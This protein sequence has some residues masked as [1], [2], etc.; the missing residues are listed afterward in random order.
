MCGIAGIATNRHDMQPA[1]YEG[2]LTRLRHRGPDDS[3]YLLYSRDA[4]VVSRNGFTPICNPE[5]L[6]LH[7]R[8][9]IVDLSVKGWQPMGTRDGRYFLVYN[10]EIYNHMELRTELETRGYHFESRSDTEVLLAAYSQWGTNALSRLLGM[11]AFAL[12]D[13]D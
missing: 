12:L 3:G 11:F 8:L 2:I 4:T 10:G 1:C 6:L 13:V 9:S 5:L 7:C